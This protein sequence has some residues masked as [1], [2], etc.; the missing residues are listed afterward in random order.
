MKTL[1][2][3]PDDRSTDFLRPV[4]AEVPYKT[5]ITGG[6]GVGELTALIRSHERIML[7]G[8]GLLAGVNRVA[9]YNHERLYF[10]SGRASVAI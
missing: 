8:H 9:R 6:I 2:V 3:H 5:V 4:D 10:K 1:V 7:M